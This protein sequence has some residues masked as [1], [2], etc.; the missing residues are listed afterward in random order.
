MISAVWPCYFV[1]RDLY[2]LIKINVYSH[3]ACIRITKSRKNATDCF[4]VDSVLWSQ[5]GL[6]ITNDFCRTWYRTKLLRL[7][8]HKDEQLAPIRYLRVKQ[9]MNL[10][11][12]AYLRIP[13]S[14]SRQGLQQPPAGP[15][16]ACNYHN[17]HSSKANKG[18][19]NSTSLPINH[20]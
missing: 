20:T 13:S 17:F 10:L 12:V 5:F 19:L 2:V 11:L 6:F 18:W 3:R 16:L 9:W 1:E 7:Q 15:E 14:L 8:V 4:C